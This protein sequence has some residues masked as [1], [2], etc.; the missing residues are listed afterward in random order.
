MDFLANFLLF[1]VYGRAVA[2]L[3]L[4]DSDTRF[5]YWVQRFFLI[6]ILIPPLSLVG[7]SGCCALLEGLGASPDRRNKFVLV[8]LF[9]WQFAVGSRS[10]SLGKD[11]L[12]KAGV[13]C[14]IK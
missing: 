5:L 7:C 12:R 1:F 14:L 13:G 11:G 4:L 9:C 3:A 8:S 2:W 10:P 6:V